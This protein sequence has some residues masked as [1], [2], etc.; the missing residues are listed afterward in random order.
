MTYTQTICVQTAFH[1]TQ[2]LTS[3]GLIR[4]VTCTISNKYQAQKKKQKQKLCTRN[5]KSERGS[6]GPTVRRIFLTQ[7][8]IMTSFHL[9]NHKI[10]YCNPRLINN[11]M[12]FA[13]CP[14]PRYLLA[15]MSHSKL[16]IQFI[17]TQK[18]SRTNSIAGNT[19][20]GHFVQSTTDP[21]LNISKNRH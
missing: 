17:Q 1:V 12:I 8:S 11:S 18:I 7:R 16:L 15:I 6:V 9:H 5:C 20:Q 19:V 4:W 10:N 14:R 13:S 3:D 21:L 2:P